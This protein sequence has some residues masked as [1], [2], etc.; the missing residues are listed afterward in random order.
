MNMDGDT[1]RVCVPS[2]SVL[3]FMCICMYNNFRRLENLIANSAFANIAFANSTFA[4]SIYGNFTYM[5]G[6]TVLH[7]DI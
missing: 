2:M 6:N 7:S 3:M 5:F 1:D 4:N